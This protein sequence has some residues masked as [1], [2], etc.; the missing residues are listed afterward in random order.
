[1]STRNYDSLYRAKAYDVASVYDHIVRIRQRYLDVPGR[2]LDHGFGNGIISAYLTREGFEMSGVDSSAGAAEL[3]RER[4]ADYGLD[5]GRFVTIPHDDA[6]LPFPDNYFAAVVSNQV[7][8]FLPGREQIDLAIREFFRVLQPGGKV[9][10]TIMAAENYYFTKF[11][12]KPLPP[13][14]R[15]R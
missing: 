12:K 15:R 13:P 3:V 9:A 8:Y 7:L 14:Q 4:A 2:A 6:R 5:S 1:M 11:G 10:A